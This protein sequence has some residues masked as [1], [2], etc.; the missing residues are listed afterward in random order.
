MRAEELVEQVAVAVFDVDEVRAGVAGDA[1]G[2]DEVGGQGF[3]FGVAE[4]LVV[5]GDPEPFVEEGMA[6]G[7][8]RFETSLIG[9]SAE[10]AGV[11]ELKSDDQVRGGAMAGFMGGHQFLAQ[12][13]QGRGVGGDDD[14]LVGIGPALRTDRHRLTAEHELRAA[15]AEPAPASADL[16]RRGAVRAGIPALHRM[17]APPVAGDGVRRSRVR[18]AV[19]PSGI[20]IR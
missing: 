13:G 9:R 4:H 14:Q 1:G 19:R 20:R 10:S 11:G 5:A 12:P 7:D 17:D 18:E 6:E 2:P 8:A 16:V 3:E 15:L